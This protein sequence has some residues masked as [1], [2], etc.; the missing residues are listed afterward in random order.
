MSFGVA[1]TT[2]IT[3]TGIGTFKLQ[4]QK[5]SKSREKDVVKDADG[6]DVQA[7]LYNPTQ[8][9]TFDY[10]VAAANQAAVPAATIIPEP[11]ALVTVANAAQY[12]AIA[13][14]TWFVWNDPEISFSNTT[15]AKVTLHL[16]RWLGTG[17]ITAVTG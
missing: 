3:G 4:T 6:T 15:A 2:G 8:E 12:P 10:V 5:H 11:G 13:D 1:G 16:K 17:G 14:T 9:A 7:T